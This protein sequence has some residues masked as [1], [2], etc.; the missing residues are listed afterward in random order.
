[1]TCV[2]AVFEQHWP[3]LKKMPSCKLALERIELDC[4]TFVSGNALAAVEWLAEPASSD[5]SLA[6]SLP[7]KIRRLADNFLP[8]SS[9]QIFCL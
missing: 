8:P 7:L 1:M 9:M 5:F 3:E 4:D 2:C 6:V